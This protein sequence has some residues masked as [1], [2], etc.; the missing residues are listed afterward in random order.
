MFM[1]DIAG[2]RV[3]YTGDYSREEDRHLQAAEILQISPDICIIESTYGVQLNHFSRGPCSNTCICFRPCLMSI[4]LTILSS[5][6]SPY[7]MLPP[8]QK[9]AWLFTRHTSTP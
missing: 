8:L 9:G 1:V 4:G 2:V 5:I 6:T 3:L 7:I